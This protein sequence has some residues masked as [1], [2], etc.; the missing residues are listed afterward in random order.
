MLRSSLHL[1]FLATS[2]VALLACGSD[3]STAT[4]TTGAGG[5]STSATGTGGSTGGTGGAAGTTATGTASSSGTGMAVMNA[6]T[7][8]ADAA[9]IMTKDVK[10]ITTQCGQESGGAEVP[11]RTCI[12]KGT[13]LSDDCASCYSGEVACVADHCLGAEGKCLIAPD[14]QLCTDCRKMYCVADY[15]ACS[16]NKSM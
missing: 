11:T 7:N 1:L 15:E 10:A 6:C 12:K 9:I 14:A 2:A 13:G 5:G 4:T 3:T 16:G 8:M